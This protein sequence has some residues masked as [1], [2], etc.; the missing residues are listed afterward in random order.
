VKCCLYVCV[1]MCAGEVLTRKWMFSAAMLNSLL[2]R[3][4]FTSTP[5]PM[6]VNTNKPMSVLLLFLLS[7]I[8]LLIANYDSLQSCNRCDVVWVRVSIVYRVNFAGYTERTGQYNWWILSLLQ[9]YIWGIW[10]KL[11]ST[12]FRRF[13]SDLLKGKALQ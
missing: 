2:F 5:S 9:L 12:G 4:H 3:T 6:N 8:Q 13:W 1:Y 7:H 11:S 10:R